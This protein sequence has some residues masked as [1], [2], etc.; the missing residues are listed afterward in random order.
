MNSNARNRAGK[1]LI[2]LLVLQSLFTA[3]SLVFSNSVLFVFLQPFSVFN[4]FLSL[5]I[6]FAWFPILLLAI[7]PILGWL[8]LHGNKNVG[9][10]AIMIPQWIILA[11]AAIITPL[12]FFNAVGYINATGGR[13]DYS[14]GI[15]LLS[16]APAI[17]FPI[18]IL[19]LT[20]KWKPQIK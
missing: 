16:G 8:Q 18:I 9:R 1:I 14:I 6:D 15:D 12:H 4:A 7:I 17:I 2:I 5:W 20:N 19:I 10:W 3:L 11:S 13:A